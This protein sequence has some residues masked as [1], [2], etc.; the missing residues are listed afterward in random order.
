[1]LDVNDGETDYDVMAWGEK[2]KKEN[3]I[4]FYVSS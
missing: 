3:V 4:P 2:W 1:M